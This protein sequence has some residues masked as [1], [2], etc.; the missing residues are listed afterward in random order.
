M[1]ERDIQQ[2]IID[3]EQETASDHESLSDIQIRAQA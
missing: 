1:S 3:A 2:L